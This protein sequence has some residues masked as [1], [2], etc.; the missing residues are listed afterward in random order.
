M[1]SEKPVAE[2]YKHKGFIWHNQ[3]GYQN[4]QILNRLERDISALQADIKAIKDDVSII[5]SYIQHK[6]AKEDKAWF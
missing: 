6:K 1:E 5:K 2:Y 3:S 4:N